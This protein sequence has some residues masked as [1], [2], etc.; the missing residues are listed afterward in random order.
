[1]EGHLPLL[2]APQAMLMTAGKPY[3]FANKGH[4]QWTLL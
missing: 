2:A 4:Q 1:L 3:S